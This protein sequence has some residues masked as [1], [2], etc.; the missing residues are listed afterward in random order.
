MSITSQDQEWGNLL[1]IKDLE[2]DKKDKDINTLKFGLMVASQREPNMESPEY[3]DKK[4]NEEYNRINNPTRPTEGQLLGN[5]GEYLK[6]PET[7]EDISKPLKS[8]SFD[9]DPN[10]KPLT[11]S[12]KRLQDK[13]RDR[14]NTG[15]QGADLAREKLKKKGGS[16]TDLPNFLKTVIN[17]KPNPVDLLKILQFLPAFTGGGLGQMAELPSSSRIRGRLKGFTKG[18]REYD[19]EGGGFIDNIPKSLKIQLLKD[20]TAQLPANNIR[21]LQDTGHMTIPQNADGTGPLRIIDL[22]GPQNPP[23]A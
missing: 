23:P 5:S 22:L 12:Q 11:E 13:L 8:K 21:R 18:L 10:K 20:A 17:S 16:A 6:D 4:I 9:I 15:Q 7:E 3:R 2:L 19:Q 1:R 14:A